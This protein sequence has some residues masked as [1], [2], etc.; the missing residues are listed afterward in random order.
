MHWMGGINHNLQHEKPSESP[1]T[2]T[3]DCE[4]KHISGWGWI[5]MTYSYCSRCWITLYIYKADLLWAWTGWG[6]SII[7]YIIIQVRNQEKHL[8]ILPV[9]VRPRTWRGTKNTLVFTTQKTTLGVAKNT[10]DTRP[11]ICWTLRWYL[12]GHIMRCSSMGT[13]S[14]GAAVVGS[15]VAGERSAAAAG[16]EGWW[17]WQ[18]HYKRP[19]VAPL[20]SLTTHAWH[21]RSRTRSRT[22]I[23]TPPNPKS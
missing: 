9:T 6:A 10:L 16:S 19:S 7:T 2:P 8:L 14:G 15:S 20:R 21:W 1:N 23:A 17:Q 4:T 11:L 3:F 12:S 5:L 18:Q 22:T 13:S